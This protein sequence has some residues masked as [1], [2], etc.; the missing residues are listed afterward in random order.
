MS[1]KKLNHRD[2]RVRIHRQSA[3]ECFSPSWAFLRHR[4]TKL[5]CKV[6]CGRNRAK[7]E[8]AASQWGWSEIEADWQKIIARKDIDAVD[9]AVP[10]R[11][12]L[13]LR[14]RLLKLAKSYSAKSRSRH[15]LKKRKA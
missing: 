2:D 3:F 7:L 5:C 4:L 14:S 12:I 8:T 1:K 6:I 13:R 15:P 11:C 10:T 9:I